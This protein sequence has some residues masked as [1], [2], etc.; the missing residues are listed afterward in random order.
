M[1]PAVHRLLLALALIALTPATALAEWRRAESPHFIVYSDGTER[2][3][4]DY[5]AKLERFDGLLRTR[6]GGAQDDDIRKLPVYLVADD[7]AL[8]IALPTL[9]EGYAG[10]YS[11]SDND[12]FAILIR[13][14]DDDILLH[15]Y[16][17]HFAA[18][19]SNSE[20]PGWLSEGFAEYF[21]T[22]TVSA[23]GN[24]TFGLPN[25][26]RQYSL[27]RN[28]WLP[29]E[30]VL[31]AKGSFEIEG[32]TG[33]DMYYAQ[34]WALTHWLLRDTARAQNLSA[35]IA[36]VNGGRDPVEALQATF[37]ITPE[38]LT[39][40]LRAYL[41]GPMTY[42]KFDLPPLT[43]EITVT[44]LSPAA[45]A[46]L[47]R[48][49]N[50]RE[51]NPEGVDGPALLAT[52][53]TTAARF[54]DDP[55]ALVTLGRAERQ[56][57]DDAAAET[58]LATAL[59]RQPDN[60]EGLLLMADI[61]EERGDLATDE[62]EGVRQRRLAQGLLRRAFETDPTDYRVYAALARIRR[63]APDYPS[64]NDLQTW[65]RAVHYAPQVM[66]IRGDAAMAMLETGRYTDAVTL[67]TPIVNNPHGGPSA[68]W[69][70]RMLEQ[71]EQQTATG[72]D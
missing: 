35:Y 5:T 66:S 18:K 19:N 30:T 54:P 39:E 29:M 10:Y 48:A 52:L 72:S 38:Q 70:R 45:D 65:I 2:T 25:P 40:Q 68:E 60:V 53:R 42:S 58:A 24:A 27:Q 55:L 62:A 51:P 20:Y 9:P 59:E 13:G 50:A 37:G 1:S 21:A 64:D 11:T 71:I 14:R 46:V 16:S 7:R 56:W 28:R 32:R 63:A 3:L 43:P 61:L 17:H 8:R 49:V 33:I 15:E 23:G 12:I 57:G 22:A 36:A 26:G 67:L 44:T 41:R 34:S 4:R 6:F 47:L 69:G 31:R